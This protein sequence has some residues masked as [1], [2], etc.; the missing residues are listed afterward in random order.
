MTSPVRKA[1]QNPNPSLSHF[2]TIKIKPFQTW[3]VFLPL[4][5]SKV[6]IKKYHL[7]LETW[8]LKLGV[9]SPTYSKYYVISPKL[10]WV[11]L[12]CSKLTWLAGNSPFP[13][14][15]YID[16]FMM[17]FPL[18]L[19]M[20]QKSQTTTWNGA[21]KPVVN[22]GINYRSLTWLF[23]RRISGSHQKYVAVDPGG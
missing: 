14:R 18:L 23:S 7:H 11:R 19:L 12:A 16:S 8:Y 10:S 17:D 22:N 5:I 4:D 6:T 13:H 1:A 21:L 20:V 3:H 15:K 2:G 9:S